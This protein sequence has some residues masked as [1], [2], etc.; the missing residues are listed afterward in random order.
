[1]ALIHFMKLLQAQNSSK[2]ANNTI[3]ANS[4]DSIDSIDGLNI[5]ELKVTINHQDDET[6]FQD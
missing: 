6:K 4:D 2:M 3:D 5:V 1:M